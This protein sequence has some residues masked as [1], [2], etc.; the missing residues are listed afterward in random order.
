[1]NTVWWLTRMAVVAAILTAARAAKAAPSPPALVVNH[2]TRQCA[3]MFGGDECT[4]CA[5]PDGW[6]TLGAGD[7]AECP[8]G[9]EVVEHLDV[10]CTPSKVP[11]CC[12][13]RHSGSPGDCEDLIIDK[14]ASQCAFV[15]DVD[16]CTLPKGWSARPR[17]TSLDAWACPDDYKWV[18]DLECSPPGE[19][20][21]L[22][23]PGL[24]LV[25]PVLLGGCWVARRP[26]RG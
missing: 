11:F 1:M 3:E 24:G 19:G 26:G 21:G 7:E 6:E 8:D 12:T 17:S 9:Y 14:G 18:D 5:I 4:R 22:T 13:Q 20:S 10:K 2:A 16:T 15:D 25:L 23:C